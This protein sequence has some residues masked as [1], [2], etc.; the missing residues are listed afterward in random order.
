M[1][2]LPSSLLQNVTIFLGLSCD[3][4]NRRVPL[5]MT[6]DANTIMNVK[7][8]AKTFVTLTDT[9]K[10]FWFAMEPDASLF[11]GSRNTSHPFVSG[12]VLVLK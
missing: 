2:N 10:H 9:S 1:T 6:A 4:I 5:A 12:T 8:Y 3:V 7:I 11:G